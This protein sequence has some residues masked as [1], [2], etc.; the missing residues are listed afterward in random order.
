MHE[1]VEGKRFRAER[2]LGDE[3][4]DLWCIDFGRS[5]LVEQGGEKAFC[6]EEL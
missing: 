2:N 3:D 6:D 1:S 4:R 5:D